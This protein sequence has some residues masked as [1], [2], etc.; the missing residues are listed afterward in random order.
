MKV[1]VIAGMLLTWGC[2]CSG[3][4]YAASEIQP[5]EHAQRIE[6]QQHLDVVRHVPPEDRV[7]VRKQYFLDVLTLALEKSRP[8]YGD[9]RLE[10][11]QKQVFQARAFKHLQLSELDVVWSMTS[12]SRENMAHPVRMPL[13][14]GLLGFRVFIVH[15]E[16][17]EAFSE[18]RTLRDL[19]H[20]TAIQGHDWP[21]T[22]ILRHNG[23]RVV[24]DSKY[25]AIFGRLDKGRYDYF[26]RGI[27]EA[28]EEL[29]TT[30]HKN[31]QVEPNLLLV[32]PAPIYFFVHKSDERL[33]S[34][35]SHGLEVALKDGS[36]DDLLFN[37]PLHKRAFD[38]LKGQTRRVLYLS[39]PLLSKETPLDREDYWLTVEQLL[40]VR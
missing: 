11:S 6:N 40:K 7:D 18:V 33:A 8:R 17:A 38:A 19:A 1:N 35:L 21:D 39:N 30:R 34:R 24:S 27:L 12:K 22:K 4:L 36:F 32:Y 25:L 13:M 9:Y 20:F 14:K 37:H 29:L 31:L 5:I 26:P 10:Q 15:K 3:W 23:L 16:K 28:W 2:V